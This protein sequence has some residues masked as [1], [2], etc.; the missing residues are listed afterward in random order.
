MRNQRWCAMPRRELPFVHERRTARSLAVMHQPQ[1]APVL[2][3]RGSRTRPFSPSERGILL[4][5]M[6][7][8]RHFAAVLALLFSCIVI[9]TAYAGFDDG[10]EALEKGDYAAALIELQP[11]ADQGHAGAQVLLGEMYLT[12]RGTAPDERQAMEWFRKAA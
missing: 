12:G 3:G 2:I 11:L 6:P 4:R 7:T 10:R 5:A 9:G 8:L 1:L